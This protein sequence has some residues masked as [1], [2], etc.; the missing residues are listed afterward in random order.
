MSLLR[1]EGVDLVF[2]P[3]PGTSLF[4]SAHRTWVVPDSDGALD[5]G[6]SRPGFFRG[7][8]TVVTKLLNMV[9]PTRAYFGQKD[10][11]Q[12]AVVRDLVSDLGIGCSWATMSHVH[13]CD[14]DAAKPGL[15]I[16]ILPTVREC[17]GLAKSSRNEYLSNVERKAAPALYKAL[18]SGKSFALSKDRVKVADIRKVVSRSLAQEPLFHTV[19]YVT[20]ADIRTM[21]PLVD[22][23]FVALGQNAR[24]D[25][26]HVI[27][28]AAKIGSTRLIDNV[29]LGGV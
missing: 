19:D 24:V 6:T 22:D 25:G 11:Q 10:A 14:F 26:A 8:A 29:V 5:E 9:Q 23:D 28:A 4:S 1:A 16:V 12:A 13:T 21:E 17:D 2:A 15:E 18:N 3:R 20:V 7:V 27:A